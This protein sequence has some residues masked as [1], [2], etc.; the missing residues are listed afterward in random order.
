M[1]D[2][3]AIF[4]ANMAPHTRR[5]VLELATW[6]DERCPYVREFARDID[7]PVEQV[8]RILHQL[9]AGGYATYGPLYREDDGMPIGS[10][11]WLTERGV[12]LRERVKAGQA[13]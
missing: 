12:A 10:S 2:A 1:A 9:A 4:A 7:M 5:V 3:D 6:D 8:R 11:Y 13:G